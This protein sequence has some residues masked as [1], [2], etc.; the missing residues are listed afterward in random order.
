M[1]RIPYPDPETLPEETRAMIAGTPINIVRLAAYAHPLLQNAQATMSYAKANREVIDPYLREVIVLRAATV[2]KSAYEQHQHRT[3]ARSAGL[4][5]ETIEEVIAGD[6]SNLS[7][8]HA[9]AARFADELAEFDNVSDQTL[10]ELR[11]HVDDHTLVNMTMVIG[12]YIALAL[13]IAVTGP[14]LDVEVLQSLPTSRNDRFE[15]D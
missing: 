8:L 6:Y 14:D 7:P 9:A 15:D 13:L 2:K 1:A 5:P 10:A 12:Q 3:I 4:A 11:S